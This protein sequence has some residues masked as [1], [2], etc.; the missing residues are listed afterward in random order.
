MKVIRKDKIIDFQ[1]LESTKLEKHIL[2]G[3]NHPFIVQMHY[4][5][6]TDVRVYFLLDFIK[7]G[8][9]FTYL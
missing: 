8:E 6:Q 4:V 5:F 3:S 1:S 9:L 7:G 2:Q